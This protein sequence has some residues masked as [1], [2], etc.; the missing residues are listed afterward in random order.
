MPPPAPTR[1]IIPGQ[2]QL[3]HEAPKGPLGTAADPV[4]DLVPISLI[5]FF[6][7]LWSFC[8]FVFFQGEN[9]GI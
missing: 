4:P 1:D 5:F 6:L 3:D 2:L 8:L 9:I 7:I